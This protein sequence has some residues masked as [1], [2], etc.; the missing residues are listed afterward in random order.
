MTEIVTAG[1]LVIGD[2]ILSG[3]TKD[4]NIGFIAEYLTNL[5]IDLKEV[6]IVADDEDDI[7]AALN[8]LRQRYDYV[9]TTGGIGPT[10]DDI[11]A[12]AVAKAF[13]VPIDYHPAVVARF[14]ERFGDALNEARLRMARIPEGAE[15]IESATIL[16]PGFKVGN[17]IVMA[18]VPSIMQAM[19][20]IVA[21]RLRVGQRMLSDS[22][23]A[24]AKE[25]DIGSPLRMIATAH[26]E[27]SIGSYPYIDDA[28][29]PNTNVVVRA[30]DPEKLKVAM[31]EVKEML[32]GLHGSR[33]PVQ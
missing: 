19:M 23:R 21:P 15:L 32:A 20:D 22:V 12:D 4:K 9:F 29:R 25:G 13:G 14:R 28:G 26:P 1:I 6:R 11:T 33:N 18:G 16:A 10:H 31:D 2:E 8:A 24:N 3:R 5:G 17:V 7:V 30:R 27:T